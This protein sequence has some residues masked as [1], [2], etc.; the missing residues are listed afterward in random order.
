V[1]QSSTFR[2]GS[3]Y[4]RLDDLGRGKRAVLTYS[5]LHDD[6]LVGT[7]AHDPRTGCLALWSVTLVFVL[8]GL[9]DHEVALL[10]IGIALGCAAAFASGRCFKRAAERRR[11]VVRYRPAGARVMRREL[12]ARLPCRPSVRGRLRPEPLVAPAPCDRSRP[13]PLGFERPRGLARLRRRSCVRSP[14]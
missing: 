4:R 7:L 8:P 11:A 1:V 2:S 10:T 6:E 3:S 13:G 14:R 5:E 12:P 9:L